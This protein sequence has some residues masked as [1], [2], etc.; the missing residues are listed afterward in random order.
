MR[1][2]ASSLGSTPLPKIVGVAVVIF[3][4]LY[5]LNRLDNSRRRARRTRKNDA[6]ERYARDNGYRFAA[7]DAS[8]DPGWSVWPFSDVQILDG[9]IAHRNVVSGRSDGR[10]F[11]TFE[12]VRTVRTGH[13]R[14]RTSAGAGTEV[15]RTSVVAVRSPAATTPTVSVTGYSGVSALVN[16]A[17]TAFVADRFLSVKTGDAQFDSRFSVTAEDADFARR[18]LDDRVRQALLATHVSQRQNSFSAASGYQIALDRGWLLVVEGAEDIGTRLR[19]GLAA[20]AAVLDN[21]DP[22]VWSS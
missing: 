11:V 9:T 10:D 22:A 5:V 19:E 17:T 21:A 18:L 13:S 2:G 8:V 15:L 20:I 7:T 3:A 4:V 14:D 6:V 12:F 16:V 1:L